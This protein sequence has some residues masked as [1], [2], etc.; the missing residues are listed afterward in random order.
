[1]PVPCWPLGAPPFCCCSKCLSP[2]AAWLRGR[3]NPVTICSVS[4]YTV[5][6]PPLM[7]SQVLITSQGS[8]TSF[9]KSSLMIPSSLN[10]HSELKAL[11]FLWALCGHWFFLLLVHMS[12]PSHYCQALSLAHLCP[13]YMWT[14]FRTWSC[15][16]I[17]PGRILYLWSHF[18]KVTWK[19]R[20]EHR[21]WFCDVTRVGLGKRLYL[22]GIG[23][24]EGI[25]M[26]FE[27]SFLLP[28]N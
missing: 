22:C 7:A 28:V 15:Q 2:Q 21:L 19:S 16:F 17:C 14:D 5:F 18:T 4:L 6:S 12:L 9:R 20:D 3:G 23:I 27:G 26:S 1:M 8:A 10:P 24:S 13:V 25:G 11:S